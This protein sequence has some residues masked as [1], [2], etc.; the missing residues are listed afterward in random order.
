MDPQEIF[1]GE[2]EFIM[3]HTENLHLMVVGPENKAE[4]QIGLEPLWDL[5]LTLTEGNGFISQA[6][7]L[8]VPGTN[9][10]AMSYKVID[11]SL[12]CSQNGWNHWDSS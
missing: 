4:V 9:V 11:C 5:L 10:N 7:A 6:V 2:S 1:A 3:K 12:C 8:K